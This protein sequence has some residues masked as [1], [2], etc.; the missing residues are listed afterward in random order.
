MILSSKV[1]GRV[2]SLV[3]VLLGR[4]HEEVLVE[5]VKRLMK[6]KVMMRTSEE[7]E[8]AAN[9]LCDHG[10]KIHDFFSEEVGHTHA[11]KTAHVRAHTHTH[12]HSHVRMHAQPHPLVSPVW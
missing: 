11:H 9:L 2:S 5:Y 7:Q 1:C 12:T 3:Q 8:E 10:D 4:L 6:G